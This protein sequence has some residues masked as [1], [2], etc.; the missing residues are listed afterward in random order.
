MALIGLDIG[1]SGAKALVVNSRG[2]VLATAFAEYPMAT[3]RPLWAEQ[4]PQ[5]WWK[6]SKQVLRSVLRKSGVPAAEVRGIGL[7]GQMHGLVLLDKNGAVLRPCIMWND[8]RTADECVEMTD[9][10]GR[11]KLLEL[12]GNL[13]L[14]GFTAPKI[15]W[16]RKHEPHLYDRIRHI[17]LPK[18]FIRYKLTGEFASE[19]S[20]ASGTVLLDVRQRRWSPDILS[21]LRV[22]AEWMPALVESI[23]STGRVTRMAAKDT[24]L[25][26]GTLVVG[27]AGDQAAGAVGSGIV[28]E[29]VVSVTIGTSGVVFAHSSGYRREAQGRLHAFCHAVPDTWH[30]MGVTLSAGGSLR[31]F[32]DALCREEQQIARKRKIDTYDLMVKSAS[33][34]PAGSEGLLFLPYIT[35]ERTPYPDP[36]ARGAFIG[37][38]V[39]HTKAHM[40]R[41]ILEGVAFSLRD[42]ME[43]MKSSGI[44]TSDIRVSGGGARS[45]VWRQILADVLGQSL[46][47]V[48]ST[49]GAPYGAALLAGVGSEVFESVPTACG[50][51]IKVSGITKPG[52]LVESYNRLYEVYRQS[53]LQ[54]SSL[55]QS[56]SRL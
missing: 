25:L 10:V 31:W 38:T 47:T 3:P 23:E 17:L 30:L 26:E 41:S 2:K 46:T 39:R 50:K 55:F 11:E 24:G 45:K 22:P 13:V 40:I 18:D 14:P 35:G 29:G 1:T 44:E 21:A 16:V 43:L 12:T 27:G 15:L 20:D 36:R 9:L 56:L 42:C 49:E 19:M 54:N 7:T 53:Y 5:D 4:N 33:R 32:R 52:K 6:A 51:V 8:Q 48:T 28:R 37:L 34:C